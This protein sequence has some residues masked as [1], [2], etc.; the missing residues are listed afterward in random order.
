MKVKFIFFITIFLTCCLTIRTY[1]WVYPEHRE[2]ALIAIEK[3]DIVHRA[4]LDKLWAEARIGYESRLTESVIDLEQT[5]NPQYLDYASW[6]AIAG[7]HSCSSENMLHNIL[8]TDWILKVAAVTAKLK[9]DLA[10]AKTRKDRINALRNSDLNLQDADPEYATRAG[11][12]NAHFLIALKEVGIDPAAYGYSCVKDSAEINAIGVYVWFHYSAMIKATKLATEILTAEERSKLILS[13]F[14]DEAFALHFLE[15]VFAAGHVAGTWGDAAQRKGTHDYYN[16]KGLKTSTWDGE[17]IILT[18]DAWMREEDAERAAI[19]IKMSIEQLLEAANGN[20]QYFLYSEDEVS[21]SPD[22][23]SVCKNN[24]MPER[25]YDPNIVALLTTTL[26]KTPVP[27]LATG[28]GELPRFRSELGLFVGFSPAAKGWLI[29]GGF[30]TEQKTIGVSGGL[31]IA[32]RLGVGL[33]GVLNEA[34]DGLAFLELGFRQDGTSSIGLVPDSRLNAYGSLYAAIPGRSAFS[35]RLR[36][37]FYILPGDLL[38]LGPALFFIDK[39]A[40]TKVGVNAVNGGFLP[41]QAGIETSFGR[42]Q[43]VLG[44]EVAVYLYGRTRE[45]DALVTYSLNDIYIISYRSTQLEFPIVEYR[46]FRSFDSEHRSSLFIQLF[47]GVDFPHNV[48]VLETF[49]DTATKPDLKTVWN[50]GLRLVFDWRHYF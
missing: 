31:E 33:D 17:Q 27:G 38:I 25:N 43:F 8:E 24:F 29:S 44:R 34:G 7:D 9:L 4:V 42:F 50:L 30:S 11:S 6:P 41:W 49:L 19:I 12:N 10:S 13:A 48:A 14:A 32:A 16:E 1:A 18:G 3:L 2:I 46:P 45:R 23:F 40:L 35:A 22:T 26:M 47:A 36:L 21:M 5:I 15:D 39:E 20:A 28:L 37:P